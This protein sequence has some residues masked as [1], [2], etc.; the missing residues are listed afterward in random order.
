MNVSRVGFH[1]IY[2]PDDFL[3]DDRKQKKKLLKLGLSIIEMRQVGS[4]RSE[5]ERFLSRRGGR[6]VPR[7][8]GHL[9]RATVPC[10][11]GILY[12]H[13]LATAGRVPLQLN[14]HKIF[15]VSKTVK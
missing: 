2:L 7:Q 5:T 9:Y 15:L 6:L 12:C 3:C 4:Y 1:N 13:P 14:C 8:T 10:S 11:H